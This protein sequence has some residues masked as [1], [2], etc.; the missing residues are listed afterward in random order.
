M[1]VAV[2][3]IGLSPDQFWS[4]SFT[5]LYSVIDAYNEYNTPKG[6]QSPLSKS[7]LD[8]LMERYPD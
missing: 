3:V 4:M 8:E 2:G 1:G 7:E 6:K 5:E